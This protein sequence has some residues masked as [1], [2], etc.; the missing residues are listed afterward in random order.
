MTISYFFTRVAGI[1]KMN[2]YICF[3]D[4]FKK[5]EVSAEKPT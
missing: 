1:K 3:E 5:L 4:Y 2:K